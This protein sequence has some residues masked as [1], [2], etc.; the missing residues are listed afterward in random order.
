MDRTELRRRNARLLME[1][2][3]GLAQFARRVGMS[4]SQASQI[5]GKNPTR[6]IGNVIAPRIEQAFGKPPGWLDRDHSSTLKEQEANYD[7]PRSTTIPHFDI[8]AKGGSGGLAPENEYVIRSI[9]VS[10]EWIKRRLPAIT[11]L[12]N[13]VIIEAYGRSMEPTLMSG[14]L[15]VV[16]TGVREVR[17]DGIYILERLNTPELEIMVKRVQ[18][19]LEGGL[20]I[21]SDNKT[22]YMPELVPPHEI[23]S[24]VRV[25]GRVVWIWAGREA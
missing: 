17:I 23:H 22:E 18:R 16:D 3:G 7:L 14:D 10:N 4:E 11:S 25:A 1:E 20:I 12:Q 6:G 8:R 2:A 5:V 19:T 21:M 13:L 24:R 9:S 15:L